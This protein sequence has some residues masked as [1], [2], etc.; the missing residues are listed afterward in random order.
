MN[1]ELKCLAV[2]NPNSG[3]AISVGLLEKYKKIFDDNNVEATFVATERKNHA[4]EIVASCSDYDVVFS[5]G[6]DGTL[7]EVVRGNFERDNKLIICPLPNGT[8]ND[9]ASMLG[10]GKNPEKNLNLALDGDVCNLDIGTINEQPFIYVVGVGKFL[11]IPYETK[12]AE[13][14]KIGYL[15]YLKCGI[16]EFV[17][18]MKRYRAEVSIDDVK[19]D[20]E[21]SMIMVS[22]SNHIAGID[23]FH[24][25]VCLDD[26]EME[27]LLCKAKNKKEL[28]SSFINY[29]ISGRSSEIISVKAHDV[30]IKFLDSPGKNWCIDGEDLGYKSSEYRIKVSE[31][32]PFLAPR[33][34]PKMKKLLKI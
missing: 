30:K 7:N 9:V 21:Y 1:K 20:G 10:Y 25:D 11:N 34:N 13:K 23:G 2:Y 27:V 32:M 14:K 15:A 8:C 5:I 28:V 4:T 18:K 31:Q 12:T 19:L 22:N 6:G 16:S 33:D 29:F 17:N 3:N 24:K 26:G